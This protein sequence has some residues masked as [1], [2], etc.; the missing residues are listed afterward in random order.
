MTTTSQKHQRHSQTPYQRVSWQKK[1]A[2][3]GP[4]FALAVVGIPVYVYIPKFYTDVVGVHIT[5]LGYLVLGVRIFDALTDPAIGFFSDRVKTPFGRRRPFIA[6]GSIALAGAIYLLF[7]P[8][9]GSPTFETVWFGILM[10]ALFLFWTVVV[11]PYESL[12]PEI[13]FDYHER[14]TLFSLRDGALIA[15]TLAAA[16][17][18]A[19]IAY[20]FDLAHDA[21]GEKTKFFYISLCYVPLVI[22]LCWGCVLTIRE[23]GKGVPSMSFHLV[24]DV[25][26][27]LQNRPFV[28]LLLSYT[29]SAFGNNLPATLI[30]YYVEYVLQSQKADFFLFLYFVFG[31]LCLPVWIQISRKKG[32]KRTWILSMA[33][34]TGAFV[35]VF[36]LGPGDGHIYGVL[37]CL[38]GIG[39]GATLALPS[40][41]Q[42]DVIDYDELISGKRREGQYVGLWSVSKKLAAAL[43]VGAALAL[44]GMMGYEPGVAQS[45]QVLLS[46]RVLYA[47]V[48]SLCNLAALCIVAAYPIDARVHNNIKKAIVKRK[49]GGKVVDPVHTNRMLPGA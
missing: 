12:G 27:M 44:L 16:S 23:Q 29:V 42:A 19:A 43:G 18:P 47:L 13:T 30:L 8:P 37:V 48:P 15:G 3:A 32:K 11:V 5:I 7:N 10:F 46:L 45:P 6:L 33:I 41:M 4:A 31:I 17:S 9:D 20:L 38:S 1:L 28:I 36:F 35:G 22:A 49:A 40:A 14:T 21:A 2:Y 39:F 25:K 24:K 34:N 26:T